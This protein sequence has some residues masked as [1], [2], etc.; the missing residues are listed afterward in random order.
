MREPPE[1]CHYNGKPASDCGGALES[2]GVDNQRWGFEEAE[3][4]EYQELGGQTASKANPEPAETLVGRDP[5]GAVEV[6]VSPAAE[7]LAV[8][9]SPKWRSSV[10]PRGLHSCVVTAANMATMQ[11]LAHGVE[12]V[13]FIA[14]A[15]A[16]QAA[17]VGADESAL[18]AQDMQRLFDSVTTE[19]ESF[20]ERASAV[21]DRPT[22]VRSAGGHV[23]GTAHYGQVLS[24]DIEASWVVAVRQGE[25]E[26]ELFEVL[27]ALRE[28]NT[29][30]DLVAGPA[31]TGI[32]ELMELVSDP[33][34]LM[35]RLGL[36]G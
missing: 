20:T 16:P 33:R 8:R 22:T 17:P 5:D 29:P 31:G 34:R 26:S 36:P 3:D 10:D 12:Q 6:V 1:W 7:V 18:T 4:W 13:D 27:R 23:Q 15:N 35:R 19:L 24:V 2:L 28:S 30:D 21:I 9:L 25:I 32:S 11:A 14:A